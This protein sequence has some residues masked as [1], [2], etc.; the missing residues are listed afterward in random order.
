MGHREDLLEGAV[1]C[2]LE[3]G[4]ASTTARDI[5]EA[6]GTNLGSIGYHYGGMANLMAAALERAV[7]AWGLSLANAIMTAGADGLTGVERFERYFEHMIESVKSQRP[8]MLATFDAF[9]QAEHSE[10]VKLMLVEGMRGARRL[11]A[12]VFHGIDG[13]AEPAKADLV[14]SFYQALVSGVLTQVLIDADD[15]PTAQDLSAA[16]RIVAASF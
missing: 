9:L 10:P 2:I 6:S 8:L 5:V 12:Q 4:Y 14:G 15:A 7:E 16:V 1:R 3:K 13:A 11:W